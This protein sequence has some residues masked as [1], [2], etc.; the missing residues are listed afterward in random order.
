MLLGSQIRVTGLCWSA[1][2]AQGNKVTGVL[3]VPSMAQ[4]VVLQAPPERWLTHPVR[5]ISGGNV[6]NAPDT[7]VHLRGT[8]AGVV[9][10]KALLVRD[11]TGE[12]EARTS[13]AQATD[14]GL[15]VELLGRFDREDAHA[16]LH[17]A[18]VRRGPD[19]EDSDKQLPLL[20][21][22]EQI[23][24]L[25]MA[26]ATRHYPVKFKGIVTFV[27]YGGLQAH[28][29]GEAEGITV[30]AKPKGSLDLRAGDYCEFEGATEKGLMSPTVTC[31]RYQA[32]GRGQWPEPMRPA[33]RQLNNGSLDAQWVEVQGVVLSVK[34]LNLVL[35]MYGGEI[36]AR[37]YQADPNELKSLINAVVQVRGSVTLAN[38][39]KRR[40]ENIS[41]DVN[42]RFDVAVDVPPPPDAFALPA[43]SVASLYSFDPAA[44]AIRPVKIRGQILLS[45][46]N[47]FYLMDGQN[48]LRV[49]P[50][51]RVDVMPGD[52][53][54]VFGIPDNDGTLTTLKQASVRKTGHA[55]LPPPRGLPPEK[56]ISELSDSSWAQV[57]G[58]VLNND[59]N[60]TNQVLEL[61]IGLATVAV[62]LDAQFGR[63]RDV[64]LQ[65]RVRV[66]GVCLAQAAGDSSRKILMNSPDAL[67]VLS[68]PSWWTWRHSLLILAG[69]SLVLAGA[70]AWITA[71]RRR[72]E[73]RTRELRS[74]IE[75]RRRA[76]LEVEQTHRQLV[77]ASRRAGQAEVAANVLHNVG[78]VLTSVNVS[79][80]HL[81]HRISKMRVASVSRT[82]ELLQQHQEDLPRFLAAGEK[83]RQLPQLLTQLGRH[84]N[85]ERTQLLDELKELR[86]N[87][88][89]INEIIATQ[90]AIARRF[91][92]LENLVVTELVENALRF[93]V[94]TYQQCSIEIRR[95]YEP[96][97]PVLTDKHT[98][99][100]I[101]VNLLQNA[102][103]ACEEGRPAQKR[104][105]IRIR[106]DGATGVSIEVAD[107]GIGI[108]PENL[109]RIFGHGFTTRK[110][111]HGF[112]LHSG[113]LAAREIGGQLKVESEGPGKGASFTL[114]LPLRPP[115]NPK[116][117]V[118][119][120]TVF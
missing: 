66:T 86:Q 100:P 26:E 17:L 106:R 18:A 90:Q 11:E 79:A 107:N 21:S 52:Q 14:K 117:T 42:S 81:A 68:R 33:W 9:P 61:Q 57:E 49:T 105:T 64:P 89:H 1:N 112:G 12:V 34:S 98:V 116:S 80:D 44:T 76:Q 55:P 43:V 30:V 94:N 60:P 101:L 108:T 40:V 56:P 51:Q 36:T 119:S 37:I 28:V 10:G 5:A 23:R 75:E 85:Q 7:L 59:H 120:G 92:V 99:L 97:P 35:G 4:V 25:T 109:T 29:Q 53:V 83:G 63:L 46:R 69:M 20:T 110:D 39:K 104:I 74:E 96:V 38:N 78:N 93:Q 77:D 47:I 102:Q 16:V 3:L 19:F 95:D 27:F 111:G 8:V 50:R 82:G 67:V 88:E 32:L 41:I 103:H 91:G 45:R 72:V 115:E 118:T 113:V 65:S 58:I 87:V 13:L 48:G 114:Q 22:I 70:F 62:E 71:L 54:E 24:R 2:T 31:R 73:Q 6:T 84:L 15:V